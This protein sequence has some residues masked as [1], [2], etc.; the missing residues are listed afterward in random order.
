VKRILEYKVAPEQAALWFLGQSGFII[1]S[2]DTVIAMDP[3][4]TDSVAEVSPRLTRLF[5]PPMD[6]SEL[7]VDIFVVTHDHLPEIEACRPWPALVSPG[8]PAQTSVSV[9]NP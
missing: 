9:T 1:K 3:Y 4:L 2:C 8:P 5:P 6:P 7:K